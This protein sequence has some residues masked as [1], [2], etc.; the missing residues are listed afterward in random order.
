MVIM[1]QEFIV[2]SE[3]CD[4]GGV[5]HIGQTVVSGRLRWYKSISCSNCGKVEVDGIGFPPEEVR[6]IILNSDGY[7]NVSVEKPN[8]I[9]AVKIVK[10]TIG[11]SNEEVICQVR[12]YP[13]IFQGTMTESEWIKN[14]L[15][16]FSIN[17][18]IVK[19]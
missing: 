11:L 14:K 3:E 12:R 18:E 7:W 19:I 5:V 8:F 16:T 10:E 6:K 13:V 4:H 17:S 2:P 15:A 1:S 9:K